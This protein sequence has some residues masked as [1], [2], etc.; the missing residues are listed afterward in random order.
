MGLLP[1]DSRVAEL[2]TRFSAP[3][4]FYLQWRKKAG[5]EV[6]LESGPLE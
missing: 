1:E 3:G 6:I 2:S 4:F 5:K